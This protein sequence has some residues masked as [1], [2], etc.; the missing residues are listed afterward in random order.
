VTFCG[1]V[2]HLAADQNLEETRNKKSI[3]STTAKQ[4]TCG[5]SNFI[6]TI[7]GKMFILRKVVSEG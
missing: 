4:A 3:F 5:Q 7:T 1:L 6:G 2:Y